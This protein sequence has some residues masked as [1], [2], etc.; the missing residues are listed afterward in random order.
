MRYDQSVQH[1]AEILRMVLPQ[2][3]RHPAAYHPITYALWYE[4]NAGINPPLKSRIDALVAE[5]RTI[6]DGLAA[7]LY[8]EL[9]L[10]PWSSRA[11][12]VNEQLKGL[13]SHF[14]DSAGRTCADAESFNRHWDEFAGELDAAPPELRDRI[15]APIA[16]GGVVADQAADDRAENLERESAI[17]AL[18]DHIQVAVDIGASDAWIAK[19]DVLA[20]RLRGYL[21][22]ARYLT[23][24]E[25]KNPEAAHG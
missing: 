15:A 24:H 20:N 18:V 6:D 17:E 7:D 11:L 14:E 10:D 12:Q 1:S 19:A 8:R 23:F 25:L 5:G 16:E 13:V 4:Y 21:R 3:P 22:P 9:I 2:L